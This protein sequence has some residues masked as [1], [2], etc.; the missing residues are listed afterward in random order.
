M[1]KKPHV[2]PRGPPPAPPPPANVPL[3]GR[4]ASP[5]P[6]TRPRPTWPARLVQVGG[7]SSRGSCRAFP[8]RPAAGT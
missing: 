2:Q 4:G 8:A 6:R 3:Q 5:R 7:R 1:R